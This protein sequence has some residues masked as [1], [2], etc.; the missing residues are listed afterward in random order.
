MIKICGKIKYFQI[1]FFGR[2]NK[3]KYFGNSFYNIHL[4]LATTTESLLATRIVNSKRRYFWKKEYNQM[5]FFLISIRNRIVE[6]GYL[7]PVV[8]VCI[9]AICFESIF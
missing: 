8:A 3:N 6:L 5:C 4:S 2:Q 9:V 1:N 7:T